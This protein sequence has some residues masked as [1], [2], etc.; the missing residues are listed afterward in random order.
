M[1]DVY[2]PHMDI[3]HFRT[4]NEHLQSPGIALTGALAPPLQLSPSLI[5]ASCNY[6]LRQKLLTSPCNNAT[7]SPPTKS[8]TLNI[9]PLGIELAIIP[10]TPE[11][12]LRQ[13]IDLLEQEM[14]VRA[15]NI[16]RRPVHLVTLKDTC[17]VLSAS[18]ITELI[19]MLGQ[20]FNL[21][22]SGQ[23]VYT[24][25]TPPKSLDDNYLALLKGIGFNRI[26]FNT[27]YL[28]AP[29]PHHQT[30]HL[31]ALRGTLKQL[32]NYE[33]PQPSW[34]F[35]Y[36][37]KTPRQELEQLDCLLSL[38]PPR[39]Q[40]RETHEPQG[41]NNSALFTELFHSLLSQN[42]SC[43]GNDC[44]VEF[45]HPIA[46]AQ[47]LHQLHTTFGG[48]N[49]CNVKDWIG[50]GPG[51]CSQVDNLYYR[52]HTSSRLRHQLLTDFQLPI[53]N[54]LTLTDRQQQQ[55][56]AANTI[57]MY[58]S[59]DIEEC[60]HDDSVE[61]HAEALTLLQQEHCHH[62]KVQPHAIKQSHLL[63]MREIQANAIKAIIAHEANNLFP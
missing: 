53:A 8:S 41:A 32:S 20:H 54:S 12:S 19:F 34:D 26:E 24:V 59:V 22:H 1:I 63:R 4:H 6:W 48:Y 30:E 37:G 23:R 13:Q 56:S 29:A 18:E 50:L 21:N 36:G 14:V 60:C 17:G 58:H 15:V 38:Q 25:N 43:I 31:R 3:D 46:K 11:L 27:E 49:S 62:S 55:C 40:L 51:L 44:F 52:N 28:I 42:Y 39:I 61:S 47:R 9:S 16:S 10:P 5:G 45:N 35:Y 2:Y 57:N 7:L 33:F